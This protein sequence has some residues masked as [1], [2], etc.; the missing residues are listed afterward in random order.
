MRKDMATGF[1]AVREEMATKQ[2]LGEV[3]AMVKDLRADVKM[4][5][6]VMVS[7]ADLAETVRRE[8]DAAPFAK[9]SEVKELRERIAVV[10]RKLGIEKARRA[11]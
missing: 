4:V 3:R 5:T 6:E 1:R 11:A 10:E 9:E 8:L 2:E 7:K